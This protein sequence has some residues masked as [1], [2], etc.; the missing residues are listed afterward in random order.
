MFL[1]AGGS[2]DAGGVPASVCVIQPQELRIT[3]LL[4]KGSFGTVSEAVWTLP[5]GQQVRLYSDSLPCSA[6]IGLMWLSG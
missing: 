2:V 4:G 1:Q 6:P 5:D 3:S